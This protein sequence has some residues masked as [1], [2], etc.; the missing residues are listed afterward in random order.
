MGSWVEKRA[1]EDEDVLYRRECE[2][3]L[4]RLGREMLKVYKKYN[5]DGEYLAV[6]IVDGKMEAHNR[7]WNTD[8]A[9]PLNMQG[10]WVR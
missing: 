5:P 4:A 3:E 2:D 7:W 8:R 6:C 9:L 10:R 1:I